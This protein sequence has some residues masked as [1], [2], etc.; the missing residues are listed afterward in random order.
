MKR[1]FWLSN[2]FFNYQLLIICI[3]SLSLAISK[4][5]LAEFQPPTDPSSPTDNN[6]GSSGHRTGICDAN[7]ETELTLLSPIDPIIYVEQVNS[8]EITFAWFVPS[9][10]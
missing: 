6:T 2:K 8:N 10:L 9:Q 5:A 4:V 7:S 3:V 1:A